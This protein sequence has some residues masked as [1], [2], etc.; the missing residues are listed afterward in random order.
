MQVNHLS[1][2]LLTQLTM[3]AL[4]AAATARGEARVVQH[5]SGARGSKRALDGVGHLR[6]EYF[7]ACDPE[8]LGGNSPGPCFDRYHQTK[9]ANSTFAMALH[10][11]LAAAGS[12][13]KSLVAE[14]GVATT[15]LA[16]NLSRGHKAQK[17]DPAGWLGPMVCGPPASVPSPPPSP[18]LPSLHGSDTV[19][20]G[21]SSDP[22]LCSTHGVKSSHCVHA[23]V[24]AEVVHRTQVP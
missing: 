11:R 18:P 7:A 5:S 13:V 17:L 2:F 20:S 23:H 9:L 16:A 4:E 24:E 3:P 15:Q 10:I 1:H 6:P 14:P 12:K 21:H 22:E 19:Y 8:S